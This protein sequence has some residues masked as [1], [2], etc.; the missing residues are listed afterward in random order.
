MCKCAAL[1]QLLPK[2]TE[3]SRATDSSAAP[4]I[5]RRTSSSS[6]SRSPAATSSTSSSCTWSS[7]R[8]CRPSAE[9]AFS[10]LSIATL[11]TSA[12]DPWMGAL[13]AIRSAISRRCRLSLV[14]SGR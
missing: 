1:S 6:F 9:I 3:T 4:A 7:I 12:A 13:S 10:T 5:S 8:D 14:R 2:P 11:M